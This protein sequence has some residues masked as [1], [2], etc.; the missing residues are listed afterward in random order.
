MWTQLSLF[1]DLMALNNGRR[2]QLC[3]LHV[4][5]ITYSNLKRSLVGEL[6]KVTMLDGEW[7]KEAEADDS[8][9][10]LHLLDEVPSKTFSNYSARTSLAPSVLSNSVSI[11]GL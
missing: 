1:K 7:L 10:Q 5:T 11:L 8:T 9:N 6:S 4:P 3:T 2:V